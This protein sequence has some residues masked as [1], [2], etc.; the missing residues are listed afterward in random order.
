[1][2]GSGW[3]A[4]NLPR[5]PRAVAGVPGLAKGA[6]GS[7]NLVSWEKAA[8]L[9]RVTGL[10]CSLRCWFYPP[11]HSHRQALPCKAVA[12]LETEAL[13]NHMCVCVCMCVYKT[14]RGADKQ[15]QQDTPGFCPAFRKHPSTASPGLPRAQAGFTLL[16][17]HPLAGQDPLELKLLGLQ[18]AVEVVGDQAGSSEGA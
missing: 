8:T 14:R 7:S 18:A 12:Y 6:G 15:Q 3:G 16:R 2:V 13:R 17:L 9:G 5:S 4:E 1:M 11:K 10:S